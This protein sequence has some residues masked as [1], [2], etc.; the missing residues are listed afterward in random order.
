MQIATHSSAGGFAMDARQGYTPLEL[1][2][3]LYDPVSFPATPFPSVLPCIRCMAHLTLA[4]EAVFAQNMLCT[5]ML[6]PATRSPVAALPVHTTLRCSTFQASTLQDALWTALDS[7]IKESTKDFESDLRAVSVL[8]NCSVAVLSWLLR[9]ST[10]SSS[11][12]RS[13]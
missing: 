13:C 5:R 4:T 8:R 9:A 6:P 2:L 3:S 1:W 11:S 12:R 7:M 10:W